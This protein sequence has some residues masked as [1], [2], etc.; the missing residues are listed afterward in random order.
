DALLADAAPLAPLR[1]VA[2]AWCAAW[3]WPAGVEPVTARAWTSFSAALRGD[4]SGLPPRLEKRWRDAT[5]EVTTRERFFHWELEFPEAFFDERGEPRVDAGFDAVIGNPPWAAAAGDLTKFSRESGCYRLQGEGHA[6]LY[7][8]FAERMLL[9]AAPRGRVGMLM[10]SGL[11]GDQGCAHLRRHLFDR[12]TIDASIGFDNGDAIFPIHRGMRFSLLTATSGGSTTELRFRTGVRSAAVLDDVPDQGDVP[13]S[14]RVPLTLVRRFGGPALAVPELRHERDRA[15]LAQVVAAAPALGSE[16]GWSARFGRELNATDDRRHFGSSGLPVLEGK[17]IDPFVARARDATHFVDRAVAA[18]LLKHRA[19]IDA[20][21]LGYR[22]VASS[23]NRLTLIAAI[24]PA[25]V[26]TTHTIFC[27]REP[28]DED[29]HWF[30]CGVFNS[31]VANYLVRL[32]GGMHVPAAVIHQL[33]VPRPSAGLSFTIAALSRE[34]AAHPSNAGARAE[35][36]ARVTRAYGLDEHDLIH[37]LSTF[38]IVPG[39][40]RAAA[41]GAFRAIRDGL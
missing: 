39:I 41:L 32:R 35:L 16:D 37:V 5:N 33:P 30:L 27:M 25:G 21:R 12:W 20:P 6:N 9:L 15:I 2:D 18:R 31:Y 26:V 24:V 11:L 8:V 19:R 40:D 38:P 22:E 10:P 23:T 34:A 3:F 7:Q 4:R 14:I 28:E 36:Q 13:D 17:L 29:V 1:A